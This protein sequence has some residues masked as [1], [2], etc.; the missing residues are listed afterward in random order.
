MMQR[1]DNLASR[2]TAALCALE[3]YTSALGNAAITSGY[4]ERLNNYYLKNLRL[5][6]EEVCSAIERERDYDLPTL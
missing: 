4:V 1:C 2:L 6:V 5:C 3:G